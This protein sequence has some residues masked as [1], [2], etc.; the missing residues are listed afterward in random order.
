[1]EQQETLAHFLFYRI[2]CSDTWFAGKTD[3]TKKILKHDF[4]FLWRTVFLEMFV[5]DIADGVI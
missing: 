4:D 3:I 2:N 1:V 5:L